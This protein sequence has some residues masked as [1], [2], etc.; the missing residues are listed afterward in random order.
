[1]NDINHQLIKAI[2]SGDAGYQYLTFQVKAQRFAVEILRIREIIEF[3]KITVVP[4]M[5]DFISG[6]I[7]IR[8]AVVPVIDLGARFGQGKSDVNRRTCVVI[9]ESQVG[10]VAQ[11]VGFLV[12]AVNAVVEIKGDEFAAPPQFGA[13]VN[14]DFL[15]GI[16][17]VADDFVLVLNVE[18]LLNF[19]I[20]PDLLS[21]ESVDASA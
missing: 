15:R 18:A 5:Q 16:G 7:N 10:E 6:V 20:P 3:S 8:G 12:D 4:M 11:V 17:K 1:M 13:G 21:L 14:I 2:E 9:L 19:E